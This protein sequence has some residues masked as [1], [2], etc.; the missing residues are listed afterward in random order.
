MKTFYI[1][2]TG[3]LM[4]DENNKVENR[5]ADPRSID[6][7]YMMDEDTKIVYPLENGETGEIEAKAGDIVVTFYESKFPNRV[8]VVSSDKWSENIKTY[9]DWEQRRKE[10]WAAE[11]LSDTVNTCGT[12]GCC[13][14]TC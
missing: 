6:D 14:A 13:E 10:E 4:L 1:T 8:V 3:K 9:K 12:C 5:Y 11:K 2:R 7:V